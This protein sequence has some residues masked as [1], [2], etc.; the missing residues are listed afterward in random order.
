MP[1]WRRRS[2]PSTLWPPPKM[3]RVSKIRSLHWSFPVSI[4]TGSQFSQTVLADESNFKLILEGDDLAGLP[5]SLIDAA[6]EAANE[7]GLAGKHVVTLSRSSIEPFLQF[8][9]R[10]DLREKAFEAWIRRGE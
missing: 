6:A 3:P 5:Q 10:R 4:S 8:S 9:T 1:P 7:R 2:R